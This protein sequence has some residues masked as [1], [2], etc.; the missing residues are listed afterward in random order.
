L[1]IWVGEEHISPHGNYLA[2]NLS[3]SIEFQN[4]IQEN[5]NVNINMRPSTHPE[6]I[7]AQ[8]TQKKISDKYTDLTPKEAQELGNAKMHVMELAATMNAERII[9][10]FK[11]RICFWVLIFISLYIC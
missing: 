8:Y 10:M 2:A 4:F 1:N 7:R 5:T 3:T 6:I 11:S 9:H